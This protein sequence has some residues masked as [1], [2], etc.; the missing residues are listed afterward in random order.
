VVVRIFAFMKEGIKLLCTDI[1][2]TLLNADRWLSDATV[3]AFAKAKLPTILAS[4]RMPSALTYIQKG[5]NILNSPLIAYNGG[6]ILGSDGRVVQSNTFDLS[7]LEIVIAHQ[8]KN[9]YNLSIYSNDDWFTAQEDYWT[10]R[11]IN[12]TRVQPT[13]QNPSATLQ[14]LTEQKRGIHKLMCMGDEKELDDLVKVLDNFITQVHLYRSKDTYLEITPRNIDKA[15]ALNIVLQEEFDFGMEAV[16]AFGDNHNDDELI[17]KAGLGVA[18]GNATATLKSLADYVSP[19]SNKE[20]A[21]AKAIIE[22]IN[23]S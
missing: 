12:N 3:T 16:M 17:K 1:D 14:K 13:L 7:I 18:V 5:L 10:K 22:I 8:T 6:L 4:S 20:D 9:E 11:E 21:V 15:K 2:G 19:Y 23:P